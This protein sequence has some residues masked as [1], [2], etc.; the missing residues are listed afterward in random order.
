[1]EVE[2]LISQVEGA[3]KK[4]E[5]KTEKVE[6]E[7]KKE[8]KK[9]EPK[10]IERIIEKPVFIEKKE[11]TAE[12]EKPKKKRRTRKK[13]SK[14]SKKAKKEEVVETPEVPKVE[15]P[16]QKKKGFPWTIV[17]GI[18]ALLAGLAYFLLRRKKKDAIPQTA[19]SE[20]AGPV[21]SEEP[22]PGPSA[23]EL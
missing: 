20:P 23:V 7:V 15:A 10:V 4:T 8:E 19:P 17:L 2:E 13:S 5:K 14:K 1:M 9:E 21:V 18:G 3:E 16:E 11:E 22:E 6:Q 12:E